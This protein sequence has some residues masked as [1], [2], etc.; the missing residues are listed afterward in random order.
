MRFR[1]ISTAAVAVLAAVAGMAPAGA[2]TEDGPSPW[3]P[4]ETTGFSRPAGALCAFGLAGEVVSDKERYRT[5]ETFPDGSPR[6]QEFT[7]QL[8]IRFIN[9]DTGASVE[10]NLTG[11]GDFEY[12]A[13]GSWS[14]TAVGGHFGGGLRAGDD[15]EQGYYVVTG[16]QYVLYS[17]AEGHR[18][19]TSGHGTV[20]NLCETLA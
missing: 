1:S 19:L 13:D 18:T 2:S 8:V 6:V 20:E 5:T 7:G 16:T 4:Y 15:P 10:R 9:T 12:F 11:R 3:S 14:L 17:D